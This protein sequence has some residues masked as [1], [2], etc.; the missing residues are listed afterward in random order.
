[1][2]RQNLSLIAAAVCVVIA[3]LWASHTHFGA[4][5]E[6]TKATHADVKTARHESGVALDQEERER[7]GIATVAVQSIELQAQSPA[8]ATV[9]PLQELID[10]AT[11]IA[12]AR[13]QDERSKAAV[14]ASRRDFERLKGLHAQDRNVSDRALEAAEATWRGDDAA[15]RA[16]LTAL[17]AARSAVRA[18]WGS[19]LAD[20]LAARGA[21]W[22]NLES[23]RSLLL[24]VTATSGTAPL[25][26]PATIEVKDPDGKARK[27]RL[28]SPAP[29]ADARIQGLAYWYEADAKGLAPGM[30]LTS[31]F[32]AGAQQTGALL[33]SEALLWWKGKQWAYAEVEAG[34]FERR[35]VTAA[36]RVE[37]GWFAPGFPEVPV[38]SRGAQALLSQELKSTIQAGEEEK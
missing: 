33:P 14:A 4:S 11:S 34:R 5:A 7:A 38:V 1:M 21:L 17:D 36:L 32:G 9:L 12:V 8:I 29:I 30:I 2:N 31:R 13:A 37:S 25:E 22:R 26:M 28:I 18:R 24:R 35:E 6:T 10:A 20:S 27:A 15:A 16:S 3:G 19:A 23:G